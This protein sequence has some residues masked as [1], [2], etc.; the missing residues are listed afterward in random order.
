MYFNPRSPHGER[1]AFG[2]LLS[3][4]QYFNPR[5]PHGERRG[6][7][8]LRKGGAYFNP[9]SPHG[10]RQL[11]GTYRLKSAKTISIHAPRT[12]SD[13]ADVHIGRTYIRFQST[14]PA[15]G[16]T[17]AA[18]VLL[19]HIVFQSTLPARGATGLP[20][21]CGKGLPNFNPRSPH[22]ERQRILRP[23]GCDAKISIHAPR[24]GSDLLWMKPVCQ[25]KFQSTLPARGATR[26]LTRAATS[27]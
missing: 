20:L 15:R 9:R 2:S 27:G 6:N 14:L 17:A 7:N 26:R 22:G 25:T 3:E 18:A 16:A 23:W 19:A 10:E 13:A 24:T 11:V 5:S 8:R 12:G 1:R 21:R 4:G